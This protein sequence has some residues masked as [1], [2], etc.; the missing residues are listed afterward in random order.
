MIWSI[1]FVFY[2]ITLIFLLKTDRV[3]G[4]FEWNNKKKKWLF[5]NILKLRGKLYIHWFT[6]LMNI[7][8]NIFLGAVIFLRFL[9]SASLNFKAIRYPS[10]AVKNVCCESPIC[11]SHLACW[12]RPAAE[13]S[14]PGSAAGLGKASYCYDLQTAKMAV[15][16]AN[17]E[18]CSHCFPTF[19][20]Y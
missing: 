2:L 7:P 18:R 5:V 20:H 12:A 3:E 14:W 19:Y 4:V 8:S 10:P 16:G 17:L 1:C 11:H 9:K 6:S 15:R 13:C